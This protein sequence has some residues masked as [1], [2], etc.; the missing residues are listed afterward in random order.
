MYIVDLSMFILHLEE[1]YKAFKIPNF[2]NNK[3]LILDEKIHLF[4]ILN[5]CVFI[6]FLTSKRSKSNE[7]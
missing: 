3:N 2:N 1:R 5:Y 7:R 6:A 4:S